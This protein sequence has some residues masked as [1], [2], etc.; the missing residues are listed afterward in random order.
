MARAFA[1]ISFTPAVL[2]IQKQQGSAHSYAKFLTPEAER[3]DHLTEAEKAFIAARDGFYQATISETGW[4]YVQFRGG[5]KGFLKTINDRTIAYADFRGNRQYV[6]TGNLTGIDKISLILMDYPNQRRLKI[7]GR[8]KLIEKEEDA[9]L[10]SSLMIDGYRAMPERAVVI[11]IEAFDWNC[12]RHIPQRL[13]LEELQPHILPLQKQIIL[14]DEE[15][16]AL[17]SQLGS[18]L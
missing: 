6:S 5:P 9:E 4:P 10:L 8:A 7:W 16:K 12:P 14:L 18:A 13:T 17:K 2:N 3:G 15:N 1:E 11:T